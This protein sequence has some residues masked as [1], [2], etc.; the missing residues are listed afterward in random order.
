MI[1]IYAEQ[2][3]P[4]V[5]YAFKWVLTT[6]LGQPLQWV[7]SVS[8]IEDTASP[9]FCYSSQ[10]V[11]PSAFW[12]KPCGLLAE[13]TVD[14]KR[15]VPMD[16]WQQLPT[17]FPTE[18]DLSFDLFAAVFYLITRYEEYGADC[19]DEVGRYRWEDSL[20]HRREFLQRPLVDE[21][22]CALR[23]LLEQRYPQL[24]WS[25]FAFRLIPIIDIDQ[26][27]KYRTNSILLTFKQLFKKMCQG[28]WKSIVNQ[29]GV[30]CGLRPDPYADFSRVL[31]IHNDC[32]T[33][34][35]FFVLIH[36]A[37]PHDNP[38]LYTRFS[39][40]RR[41]LRRN[42]VIGLQASYASYGS[43]PQLRI[44]K[45]AL[46]KRVVGTRVVCNQYHRMRY[47]YHEGMRR[48]LHLDM[49]DD[50][51]M[52]YEN[53]IGFRAST[54]RAFPF[55]DFKHERETRL[56]V[57]PIAVTDTMLRKAGV[58]HQQV[59]EKLC[60]IGRAVKAVEGEM[61]T[62]FHSSTLLGLRHDYGW[63]VAYSTALRYLLLL[64]KYS[65]DEMENIKI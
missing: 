61:A 1:T 17:L 2:R 24:S 42:Y 15:E 5:E 26:E 37:Y 57:H 43:L 14:R 29:V 40:L 13:T 48:L 54:C 21:W 12:I 23:S 62:T 34:P 38:N 7:D 4:R 6:C 33:V 30:Y 50:Y 60:E 45:R 46:E 28:R 31:N 49:R 59:R 39:K 10:R 44:E 20:A 8:E 64:E 58:H 35:M 36:K 51:S 9:V 19:L 25:S 16:L 32:G 56:M 55:Y 63:Q 53:C 47:L 52:C 18:G 3:T 11:M 27:Y 65:L 22:L 41:A